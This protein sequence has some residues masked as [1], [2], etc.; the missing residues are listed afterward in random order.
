MRFRVLGPPE[1]HRAG[2]TVA[3]GSGRQAALLVVLLANAGRV[4]SIDTLTDALWGDQP[5]RQPRNAIQTHVARLRELL[6]DDAGLHTRH[7]GYVLDVV[8]DDLDAERFDRLLDEA[9]RHRDDPG[10]ARTR[11]DEALALWRGA[12]F[13]GF[14]EAVADEARRLD[15][16]WLVAIEERAAAHLALG[17]AHEVV[18]ELEAIASRHPFRDRLVELRI[19]ALAATDRTADALEAL[20]AYRTTLVEEAGLDL[21][22]RLRELEGQLLRDE[23]PDPT[24]RSVTEDPATQRM[25]AAS[26]APS[27]PSTTPSI[28]TSVTSLVGR[29]ALV[30]EVLALIGSRRMITLTG[31]GGVGKS[32]VAAEV[33]RQ[34][35]LDGDDVAWVELASVTD[36]NTIE[37]VI[38]Q[39]VGA[40]LGA[41][42]GSPRDRL[43]ETLTDRGVL[44]VLD[45]AE[46]LLDAVAELV[47]ELHRGC[48]A[49]RVLAT[50]RERL[51]IEGE[52][53]VAVLPLP[54]EPER[55]DGGLGDAVELFLERA[56]G[57][58][59][60]PIPQEQVRRVVRICEELDGLPLAIELAAARSNVL[61]LDDL[62]TALREDAAVVVVGRRRGGPERHRD[63]WAVVDWSYR[64]LHDT[65]QRLFERL[66]VFA[67]SFT[68]EQAHA[69]CAAELQDPGATL[70]QIG[71]LVEAS[72]LV[73]ANPD[74]D[75]SSARYR[76]LRPLRSFA[77]QRLADRGER[78]ELTRRHTEVLT[79]WAEDAAGP[80]L[81]AASHRHL[82][83]ALD[84]LR[85]VRRRAVLAGDVTTLGRLVA[86]LYRFDYWRAGAELL[87]WG[88]DALSFE[89][90][91]QLPTAPQVYAAA[92]A[93]AWRRG[94]LAEA[95]SRA[96]RGTVL[97]HGPDDAARAPA[98]EALGDVAS[99]EGRLDEAREAFL[100]EARLAR[101]VRDPDGEVLGLTAVALTLAYAGH[102]AEAIA[103]ADS[104][105]EVAA[106][107]GPAARAFARYSQGECRAESDP[108]AALPFL[109]EAL[110]LAR[111]HGA[112][113][114]EGVAWVTLASLRARHSDPRSAVPEFTGLLEHWRRSGNWLQQWTTLRNLAEVLTAL[115]EDET[116]VVIAAASQAEGTASPTF[117]SESDRLAQV[118]ARA[119]SRL[120]DERLARARERGRRLHATEV[121]DLA[122]EALAHV[123]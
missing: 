11:L 85:E 115:G 86:A 79:S 26:P 123:R 54:A 120:G 76:L 100:E 48:P 21:S 46:H 95:R 103:S 38:G 1:V 91:D 110:A 22:T 62:F 47:D 3:I 56:A 116:A 102:V 57:S 90:V 78:E 105:G 108:D 65:E 5:P 75:G 72:L 53:I 118:F 12:A 36:P 23:L 28:P 58:H 87:G 113:F 101:L 111:E 69:V 44:L 27:R 60:G 80:P 83:A 45:N 29:G 33:A 71:T 64:L 109:D 117:G 66:G 10:A 99:F 82:E 97:G 104:A 6:G 49:V 88:E 89:G 37:H 59:P 42:P 24:D 77:R 13:D 74:P 70:A 51:S 94:D 68:G 98:F 84:D 81:T 93:A 112:R 43:I 55:S 14:E 119:R 96:T 32:R 106:S 41:A 92:A 17:L 20:R 34:R 121:V 50:S 8:P 7:P 35:H 19:R 2:A 73:R 16:R 15:E 31:P 40:D 9:I 39:Q 122:L 30:A 4:V 25:P 61:T 52:R 107:A 114:T 18:S 63:L 67:G